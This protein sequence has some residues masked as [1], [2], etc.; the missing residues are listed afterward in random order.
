MSCSISLNLEN[1]RRFRGF[2]ACRPPKGADERER[3]LS[4]AASPPP[5]GSA[6]PPKPAARGNFPILPKAH[7]AGGFFRLSHGR[8]WRI[9]F[10]VASAKPQGGARAA[11]ASTSIWT[12]NQTAEKRPNGAS[13]PVSNG[14]TCLSGARPRVRLR[15]VSF[16]RRLA[17][18]SAEASRRRAPSFPRAPTATPG[19]GRRIRQ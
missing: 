14:E 6:A 8:A 5:G 15:H 18:P 4:C 12:S 1:F 13:A 17:V 11:P 16:P 19:K 3:S 7:P 9:M 10:S 2:V